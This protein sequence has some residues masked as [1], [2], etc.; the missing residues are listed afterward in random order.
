MTLKVEAPGVSLVNTGSIFE[1]Q[2]HGGTEGVILWF[3]LAIGRIRRV[4]AG[5]SMSLKNPICHY[6]GGA[7]GVVNRDAKLR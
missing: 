4:G 3:I 7:E 5:N 1:P 6:S 2:R